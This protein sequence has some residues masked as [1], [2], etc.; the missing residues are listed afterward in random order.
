MEDDRFSNLAIISI[1]KP[2]LK[3]LRLK[4]DFYDNVI[5]EF[6]KSNRRMELTYI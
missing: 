5:K 2:L 4:P 6:L 3:E 1:E